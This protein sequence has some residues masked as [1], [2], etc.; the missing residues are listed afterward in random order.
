MRSQAN[1]AVSAQGDL[2]QDLPGAPLY[3][4]GVIKTL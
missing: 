3:L 4:S 2:H 1:R